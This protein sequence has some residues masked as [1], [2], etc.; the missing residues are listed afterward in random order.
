M[1]SATILLAAVATLIR[2]CD[3]GLPDV[4]VLTAVASATIAIDGSLDVMKNLERFTPYALSVLREDDLTFD[5][6]RPP[7]AN[8]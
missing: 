5:N 6:R 1:G 4:V 3:W 7:H 2:H 8:F